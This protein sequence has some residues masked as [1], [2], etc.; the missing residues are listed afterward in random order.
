RSPIQKP[1]A[2][3]CLAFEKQ[4][5][6]TEIATALPV[7]RR[8]CGLYRSKAHVSVGHSPRILREARSKSLGLF[9]VWHLKNKKNS[10]KS[11]Q[12]YRC[13]DGRVAYIEV[14]PM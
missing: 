11:P 9:A 3:C 5:K 6:L 4:Q 13:A 10:P 2:F 1:R 8:S 12:H 7:R 14:K